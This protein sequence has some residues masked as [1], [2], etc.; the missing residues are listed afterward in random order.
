MLSTLPTLPSLHTLSFHQSAAL[1]LFRLGSSPGATCLITSSRNLVLEDFYAPRA[2][3]FLALFPGVRTLALRDISLRETADGEKTSVGPLSDAI[4]GLRGLE[5]LNRDCWQYW[6]GL[7]AA[8][9]SSDIPLLGTP[10]PPLKY[11][12]LSSVYHSQ[13]DLDFLSLVGPTLEALYL[14][15]S[16]LHPPLRSS[17]SSSPANH[18][19]TIL[20]LPPGY[21][22][23]GLHPIPLPRL[24]PRFFDVPRPPADFTTNAGPLTILRNQLPTLL[25]VEFIPYLPLRAGHVRLI[26]E[27]CATRLGLVLQR[28]SAFE[29]YGILA[30]TDTGGASGDPPKVGVEEMEW[31]CEELDGVLEFGKNEVARMRRE[32]DFEK[33][34]R[35]AKMLRPLDKEGEKWAL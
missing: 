7:P 5:V 13:A 10:A 15:V 28:D 9:R 23:L 35:L 34:V 6:D 4:A 33:G 25:H 31:L 16:E 22:G 18:T 20:R 12:H 19:R 2:T 17:P 24:S 21:A 1:Q 30:L 8:R 11:L 32:G 27:F 14:D 29:A 26:N 3:A